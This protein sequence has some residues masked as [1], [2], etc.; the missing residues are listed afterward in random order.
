MAVKNLVL[1]GRFGAPHGVRGEIR[2]QSFTGDPLAIASYGP[3]TDKSGKTSVKLLAVRPQ[4][5]DM[6]VAR[7][8]GVSDRG[9]A[10]RL[11][12]A[13]LYIARDKLPPPEDEDEFYLADLVGLR[14]ET[15]EGARIGTVVAVRNFGA[16]DILEISPA[17]GG[18][19]L[20][21]PFTRSVAPVVSVSE[22]VVIIEPPDETEVEEE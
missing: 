3:L 20:M 19:T 4:G 10:E 7:V 11:T 13:E 22:G 1:L 14:A 5:K 18:E 12:G 21:F 9:G 8:E 2:L 16:G 17:Q 6:L 15:R